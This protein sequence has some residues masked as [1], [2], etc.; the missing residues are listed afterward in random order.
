MPPTSPPPC[1]LC[2]TDE[3]IYQAVALWLTDRAAA[4]EQY[5]LLSDWITSEVTT[6]SYLFANA[7]SFNEDVSGWDMQNVMSIDGM[8][9]NAVAFDGEVAQ[10]NVSSVVNMTFAFKG[11]SSFNQDVAPW[12]TSSV[13]RPGLYQMFSGTG[14]DDCYEKQVS[15]AW[16]QLKV[17]GGR[18]RSGL[19][20]A[21]CTKPNVVY[22]DGY[23]PVPPPSSTPSAPLGDLDDAWVSFEDVS[24]TQDVLDMATESPDP[25]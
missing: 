15:D 4:V 10:W 3:D 9:L 2:R 6:M 19:R 5:G 25:D 1:I 20:T 8:F 21:K 12:D 22:P 24:D 14:M 23:Y 7:T 18:T 17:F 13:E 16:P 11:A